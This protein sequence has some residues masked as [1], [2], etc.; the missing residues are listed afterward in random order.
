MNTQDADPS[1]DGHSPR[2]HHQRQPRSELEEPLIFETGR[3]GPRG[4][5]L[6]EPRLSRRASAG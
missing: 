1:P 2:R 4:V 6:P 3:P 5:D